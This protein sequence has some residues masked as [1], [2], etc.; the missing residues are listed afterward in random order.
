MKDSADGVGVVPICDASN[1]RSK[2]SLRTRRSM[3]MTIQTAARN[4]AVTR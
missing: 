4:D 3:V 2:P 1:W